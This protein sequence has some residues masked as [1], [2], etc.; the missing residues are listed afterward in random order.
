MSQNLPGKP[1]IVSIVGKSDSGKTTLIEKLIPLLKGK[2]YRVATIKHDAHSFDIDHEGKD[3]WRHREAGADAVLISSPARVF[4]TRNESESLDLAGLCAR[5]P[6]DEYDLVITEGFKRDRARKI[7]VHRCERSS[8]L[9]YDGEDESIIAVVSDRS[10]PEVALPVF[11]LN[12]A[13]GIAAFI[14]AEF[15]S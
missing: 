6:L 8:E 9:L 10:W 12:D 11:D 3:S 7:E 2:G 1:P 14:A 5:Y 13:A 15:L 4:L